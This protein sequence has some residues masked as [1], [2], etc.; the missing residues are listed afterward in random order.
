MAWSLTFALV[1]LLGIL[2]GMSAAQMLKAV[3][4][5]A[6]P[7]SAV[8]GAVMPFVVGVVA[9]L[10]AALSTVGIFL[11]MRT[12]TLQEVQARLAGLEDMLASRPDSR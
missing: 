1:L 11:R 7:W 2:V 3:L 6:V 8:V 9:L 10:I 4:M 5:G 12:D